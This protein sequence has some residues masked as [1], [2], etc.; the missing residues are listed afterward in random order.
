MKALATW[1]ATWPSAAPS[2]RVL[3]PLLE[4]Q[5]PRF[6]GQMRRQ[7]LVGQTFLLAPSVKQS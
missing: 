4:Q 2:S 3:A 1:S 5:P 7:L 6:L